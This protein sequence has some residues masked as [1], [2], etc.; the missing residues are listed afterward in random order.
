M[1]S[2][3]RVG[4]GKKGSFVQRLTAELLVFLFLITPIVNVFAEELNAEMPAE[5]NTTAGEEEVS[6]PVEPT[7]EVSGESTTEGE[8]VDTPAELQMDPEP[9]KE[10]DK[11]R[12]KNIPEPNNSTGALS[13]EYPISVVPGRNNMQPDLRLIY[14]SQATTIDSVISQGWSVSIPSIERINRTGAENLFTNDYFSSSMSDELVSLGSG[15]YGA[16]VDNGEFISYSF[17]NNEWI[18]VDKQGT[19]Y[20]FGNSTASRQDNP[21]NSS[22]IFKWMLNE[23]RDTN[24]NYIKYEY[25]KNL[26][27]IYPNKIKYT[28]HGNTDGIFEIEFILQPRTDVT[29]STQT[30]FA[31]TT[32]SKVQEI[33]TK[34]NGTWVK[35]L[36]L[37]YGLADNGAKS[38]LSSVLET[39]KDENNNTK[40]LPAEYFDYQLKTKNLVADPTWQIP[41]IFEY[42]GEKGVRMFDVNG[43]G[44]VDMI[45]SFKN[46]DQ[47]ID[48]HVYINNGVNGWI[49]DNN[50]TVP[51]LFAP[52]GT[53]GPSF[54]DVNGDGLID[55]VQND[56]GSQQNGVYLNNGNGTGWT[57]NTSWQ[58]PVFFTSNQFLDE[59]A[60]LVD[61]NGDGLVDIIKSIK[62]NNVNEVKQ[63]YLNTGSGWGEQNLTWTI[64]LHFS[65]IGT[66]SGVRLVDINNDGNVDLIK[67]NSYSGST[68]GVYINNGN[69]TGWTLSSV[70]SIGVPFY[71]NEGDSGVRMVDINADGFVDLL[72]SQKQQNGS[73]I[74]RVYIN[75]GNSG[76]SQDEGWGID[77]NSAL[78][79]DFSFMNSYNKGVDLGD[80]NGDGLIDI[81]E[82]RKQGVTPIQNVYISSGEKADL[83][84]GIT[85]SQGAET[86]IQY[87]GSAEYRDSSN[88]LLNPRLLLGLQTVSNISVDDSY[89][90]T[91]S[92]SYSYAN[93]KYYFGNYLDRKFSGFGKVTVTDDDGNTTTTSFHGGTQNEPQYGQYQDHISKMG[94]PYRVEVKSSN[95]NLYSKNI[96]R[97]E[98]VDL[99]N[100]RN[101]V[102]QTRAI[103]LSYDGNSTHKDKAEIYSYDDSNGNK[104]QVENRGEVVANDD[105]SLV[106]NMY[107]DVLIT[108]VTYTNNT[109][110]G[111]IGLPVTEQTLDINNVKVNE[112]RHYY[113]NLALGQVG[114]GNETKTE[115]WRDGTSYIDIEKIYNNFGL[116]SSEKDPRD[117]VTSYIYD[118]YNLFPV[119][120]TNPLGQITSYSYDYSSGNVKQT[121][122]VNGR[123]FSTVYDGLDRATEEKQPDIANPSNSVTTAT[124]EYTDIANA[125]RIKKSVYLDSTNNIDSYTYF[126]GLGR[127]IQERTETETPGQYAV[128][129]FVYKE[130]ELLLKESLP[131]FSSGTAR[132]PKSTTSALYTNYTYDTLKRVSSAV[133]AVGTTS[134]NYDDWK[135]TITDATGKIKDIYRDA[136]DNLVA[137]GEH[138]GSATYTTTYEWN[139]QKKLT[140]IT[141]ALGNIRNF[142]YDGLGR[143][144]S[145]E[146]LH[147]WFDSAY[148]TW[149]YTYDNTGNLINRLDPKGMNV[150]YTYDDLNR[151]LTEDAGGDERYEVMYEYDTCTEGVGRLCSVTNNTLLILKVY[152]ALGQVAQ[153]T[154]KI[155]KVNYVSS[156]TYDR[157]GNQVLITSPDSSKVQYLYNAAGTIDQIQRKENSDP[158]FI[159]VITNVDYNAV[160]LP[161]VMSYANGSITTNT[162]DAGE[163]YRL[164]H[165]VTTAN[166]INVQDLTYDY[167]AVGNI[168]Q[169]V[170]A[171]ATQTAK[172]TDYSYDDLHRLLTATITNSVAENV[173][174]PENVNQIQT[175][176]YDAIGNILSKSDVGNY[177]YDG[178]TG[179]N[180]ANPHAVTSTSDGLYY[181]YD[182]NGNLTTVTS[183]ALP[184]TK[185]FDWDYNNRLLSADVNGNVS[186]YAY[187]ADGQRVITNDA[188]GQTLSI[189]KEY[190]VTPDS[191]EKHIFLGDTAIATVSG[192]NEAAAPLTIHA[193]HLTGSNVVTDSNQAVD[194]LTDYYAFGTMRI[195]QQNSSHAEKRKF[196]GHELDRETGLTYANARYY[197]ATLGRWLSEDPVFQLVM[198]K[199]SVESKT[200]QIYDIFLANPQNFNS[201]S[202]VT[203][204]PLRYKDFTG[205]FGEQTNQFAMGFSNSMLSNLFMGVGRQSSSDKYFQAGQTSGDVT[206]L[207]T[208][209]IEAAAGSVGVVA[210][211]IGGVV[212]SPTGAGA[213][214][215]A[216]VA[217]E[218]AAL[219][220]HGY[221]TAAIASFYLSEKLSKGASESRPGRVTQP[222]KELDVNSR[223]IK[224]TKDIGGFTKEGMNQIINRGIKPEIIKD[225]LSKTLKLQQ[226]VDEFGRTSFR[227][228]GEKAALNFN[229]AKQLITGWLK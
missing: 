228:V 33:Q 85:I 109:S 64:P 21:S 2:P 83:M 49:E 1:S 86:T 69:G 125:F 196:T 92:T 117:K 94:K 43:D 114:A 76:W 164:V 194:E 128:R 120:V 8:Q 188:A 190:T 89:G 208:G 148:G 29:T 201:Y 78:Q 153:E 162:Y 130:G 202:Y 226:R 135:T 212:S 126:D 150:V 28:G 163:L 133:T 173:D 221:G 200:S 218:S 203:N 73:V 206:S 154:K 176:S 93:G 36:E 20:T 52:L 35:K 129:D 211:V 124:Y 225:T 187:D 193:D 58:I 182:N 216:G 159:N 168:L 222:V 44:L 62:E 141:D 146:D 65:N 103:N 172:T 101:F 104:T 72:K 180:F 151:V 170:D 15:N 155:G 79:V 219:A 22:Q 220:G 209:S 186:T 60:R 5:Q 224:G 174:G 24:D 106:D 140:K 137:V 227:Y 4:K 215:G 139:G 165:K 132:T 189:T 67:S 13:Y 118:S 142:S 204:N 213:L 167:D 97:W 177:S 56:Q 157:A 197:D 37:S 169:I 66:D 143:V 184:I 68:N 217:V 81:I 51:L 99:G 59:G 179:M 149:T 223:P 32:S 214:V 134:N 115:M 55:L 116:V 122:D 156:Y 98:K 195:D 144:L 11:I 145:A 74:R 70:W 158:G 138:N 87:K 10:P 57:L 166:N 14:N 229:K 110:N 18:A 45:Q 123:S 192:S 96:N 40:S 19:K 198:D 185:T 181:S 100:S 30:G 34:I 61:I 84:S 39:G 112:T 17:A 71:E 46:P 80:V 6:A 54:E 161:T 9:A 205:E 88:N 82:S 119:T 131:Y 26:G 50:W 3:N 107:N 102:K 199:G 63:V 147:T 171:S 175:F 121:I 183:I 47:S 105:G 23:V 108:S 160:G 210:G 53:I 111:V 207:I 41:V 25:T 7:G 12:R 127:K 90:T 77:E 42:N 91:N 136:Y 95:G 27:Q 16:K 113:D 191:T 38:V 48:K 152:N 75:N 178:S 31:V